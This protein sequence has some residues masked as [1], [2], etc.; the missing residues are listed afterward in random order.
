[1]IKS[2]E[3]YIGKEQLFKSP[4]LYA[5][6]AYFES[7]LGYS[8][9]AKKTILSS[10]LWETDD[11]ERAKTISPL[12]STTDKTKGKIIEMMG[13]LHTDLTY[14][15]KAMLGGCDIDIEIEF[16]KPEFFLQYDSEKY[17]AS[18]KLI[19]CYLEVTGVKVSPAI[20]QAHTKALQVGTAKYSISRG[21]V[22]TFLIPSGIKQHLED[23]VITG[24]L[25]RRITFGLI[26]HEAF[27]GSF[28]TQP[29][30]F[31]P[32]KLNYLVCYL[33]GIQ[34]PSVALKPDFDNELYIREYTNFLRALNQNSTDALLS[35]TKDDYKKN[36]CLYSFNFAPDLSNGIS[37]NG[38]AN[39]I[40]YGN[41][42]IQ[43][44]FSDTLSSPINVVL[45]PEFDTVIELTEHRKPIL[46]F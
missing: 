2:V 33:N 4:K 19:D 21:D 6:K 42:R 32:H 17:S 36:F 41:L 12:S 34:F 39:P 25:P 44:G 20:V 26:A 27:N 38:H 31:A 35:I 7:L 11:A 45:Y 43:F 8:Q 23:H 40:E 30:S 9:Q 14:Q 18:I 37:V 1:M 28:K 13:R 3:I 22:K 16:N 24:Q 29:Y 15:S 10:A 5:F 46:T